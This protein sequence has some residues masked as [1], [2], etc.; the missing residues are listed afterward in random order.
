MSLEKFEDVRDKYVWPYSD[1]ISFQ[2][3][4][5]KYDEALAACNPYRLGY[6]TSKILR[7]YVKLLEPN[8][9]LL[10]MLMLFIPFIC[11]LL[12]DTVK[13][14]EIMYKIYLYEQ[15]KISII[16]LIAEKIR[17]Q[18]ATHSK[19][20]ESIFVLNDKQSAIEFNRI[21]KKEKIKF[22]PDPIPVINVSTCRDIRSELVIPRKK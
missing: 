16:K 17:F 8:R 7:D 18:L 2:Y 11:F 9:I 5:S 14:S 13:V 10:T 4:D 12:P 22:I 19:V 6:N 15:S 1:N 20:I 21:Y 3:I